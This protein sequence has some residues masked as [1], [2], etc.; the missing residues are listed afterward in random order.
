LP[1]VTKET[2]VRVGDLE[3]AAE[4]LRTALSRP[5]P[6]SYGQGSWTLTGA[7]LSAFVVQ[8]IDPTK[9]GA[10][11]H[12][13]S[14]DQAKLAIWLLERIGP[15]VEREPVNA[16]VGWNEGPV[17]LEPSVDGIT[18]RAK[19]L[20]QLVEAQFFGN[21]A[22][23]ILPVT[24]TEPEVNS[25]NLG[26][27]GITMRL[28]R[29]DS[30][31]GNGS[32]DRNTNVEI[33]TKLLN[34][35]LIPPH[36][37][38]SLNAAI[39]EITADKGY[40]ESQVVEAE[41]AGRDIGGGICQVSTTVFRAALLAGLPIVEWWPHTYRLRGY[42]VDGWGPGY[43][44]SI[45]QAGPD[46]ANWGDFKF[47][48]PTDSWMLVESWTVDGYVVVNLYGPDLGYKVEFSET[49][50][51]EPLTTDEDIEVVNPEL[52]PGTIEQTEWPIDGFEV[53]FVRSVYDRNGELLY[54]RK[55]YTR[56]RERANVY[57]VSPDME[58]TSPA[59]I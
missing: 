4:R 25:N 23:I 44:A 1:V 57:Q 15:D 58:G 39:G 21:H 20:A 47:E 54:D 49:Y 33:G 27:L 26:A 14:L 5:V 59:S 45:L 46:P 8:R 28:A 51:S 17:A 12:V 55:F 40:V 48:N 29:G 35:T 41:R 24:I 56:F 16:V 36:A 42:E 11:A 19:E 22:P 6:L 10:E 9:R 13:M 37:T 50:V 31:Y 53:E 2:L 34:N 7:E 30:Y 3:Q 43:D 32:E 18:L 52:D 38:F